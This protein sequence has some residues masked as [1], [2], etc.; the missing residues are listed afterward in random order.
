MAPHCGPVGFEKHVPVAEQ[1]PNGKKHE[2]PDG[3][4][5]WAPHGPKGVA[6]SEPASGEPPGPVVVPP[7]P[8]ASVATSDMK[9][10]AACA[11]VLMRHYL[12]FAV[13]RAK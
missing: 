9:N 12:S 6:P 1:L 4:S 8:I 7:Q 11:F 13:P 3:H 2:D 5:P 10:V